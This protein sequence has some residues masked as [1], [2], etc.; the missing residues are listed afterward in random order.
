M[1]RIQQLKKLLSLA[2]WRVI[3][4]VVLACIVYW[5]VIPLYTENAVLRQELSER[6]NSIIKKENDLHSARSEIRRLSESLTI[7]NVDVKTAT[8]EKN[9]IMVSLR[10]CRLSESQYRNYVL[11]QTTGN[12]KGSAVAKPIS[13]ATKQKLEMGL[14]P[15]KGVSR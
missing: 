9:K 14:H 4:I 6:D 10:E 13:D 11:N 1:Y 3:Y 7:A 5:G 12:K 2:I 15:D 8:D